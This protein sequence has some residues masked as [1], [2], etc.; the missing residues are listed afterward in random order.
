M[1]D[2]AHYQ[3]NQ[4]SNTIPIGI[5]DVA[6]IDLRYGQAIHLVG[7]SSSAQVSPS[8]FITAWPDGSV[9]AQPTNATT[10]DATYTPDAPGSYRVEFMVNDGIDDDKIVFIF[11]VTRD[12]NGLIYDNAI[13]EPAFG[14]EVGEDN[15]G[16]NDRG[17]AKAFE[18]GMAAQLPAISSVAMLL[19][20]RVAK[21]KHINLLGYY[22]EGDGGGGIFAW[23]DSSSA[24]HNGG[25]ILQPGHGTGGAL[26]TG[27]WVRLFSG[28]LNVSWFGAVNG[29]TGNQAPAINAAITV[30][31][32]T[33][34]RVKLSGG[35][36]RTTEAIVG[37]S[38]VTIEGAGCGA[39]VIHRI[40]GTGTNVFMFTDA[41]RP[42]LKNLSITND[43]DSGSCV[44]VTATGADIFEPRFERIHITALTA[45]GT[46][47]KLTTANSK[48]LY[49]AHFDNIL[50]EGAGAGSGSKTGILLD[51]SSGSV[52][53]LTWYGGRIGYC[54]R[55][56]D[57]QRAE[58]SL[59]NGI[60]IYGCGTGIRQGTYVSGNYNR[61]VELRL[62]DNAV[63]WNLSSGPYHTAIQCRLI[64]PPP[65][66]GQ[67]V[68]N[69]SLTTVEGVD[70]T[71]GGLTANVL[72]SFV[73]NFPQLKQDTISELT[74]DIGVT[75]DSVVL[76]D[77]GVKLG[78]DSTGARFR[79]TWGKFVFQYQDDGQAGWYLD[80]TGNGLIQGNSS[81]YAFYNKAG[82]RQLQGL[83]EPLPGN[84]AM[85]LM[86]NDGGVYKFVAVSLGATDTGDTGYRCLQV[87]NT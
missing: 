21:H 82:N 31:A 4:A 66:S 63:Q 55:G 2:G 71:G 74:T 77:G 45:S 16:G 7:D 38:G 42:V 23:N 14:E 68:D 57:N 39:T 50:I 24:S 40:A 22:T 49:W 15:V 34:N 35:V 79:S 32:A 10:F 43:V 72:E 28:A 81:E 70:T 78:S 13:R 17:Y 29:D 20:R 5:V 69:A 86:W 87:P 83:T 52:V 75:I 36:F 8:W 48:N 62:E 44:L 33:N 3:I 60:S 58:T 6:R 54:D 25:T 19:N 76:K 61:Y 30:A 11:A 51:G 80:F 37:A 1:A 64:A 27:R 46:A 53:G 41:Q 59:F 73:T 84:S 47:F 9:R 26:S 12:A 85:T 18:V 67:C 65:T 56:I